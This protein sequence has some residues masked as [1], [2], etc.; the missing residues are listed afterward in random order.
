[1][2]GS[3][4]NHSIGTTNSAPPLFSEV[5]II[6]RKGMMARIPSTIASR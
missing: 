5:E 1:M 6:Q 2:V 3:L 4:G